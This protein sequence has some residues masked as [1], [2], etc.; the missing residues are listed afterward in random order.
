MDTSSPLRSLLVAGCLFAGCQ[1]GA[2]VDE[3]AVTSDPV[4]AETMTFFLTSIG[5][6]NGAD[7]GGLDG[8]DTHC[9][10]LAEAAGAPTR[11]WRAYLST[12]TVDARDRIGA[13]PWVNS[14]GVTVAASLE[15]LIPDAEGLT[16]ASVL[17]EVGDII[18]GRGDRPNRH[19]VL[20]GTGIDGRVVRTED[21]VLTCSDWTSSDD[22]QAVV[23]HH[24]RVGGGQRPTHWSSA[25]ASRGCSQDNLRSSGGDGLFYC[26]AID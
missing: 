5:P 11:T 4:N 19:D 3:D 8:A 12:A 2:S 6:G 22:G 25:H 26:F 13:G 10:A 7:L 9:A 1:Q 21:G 24:D 23:G 18:N 15:A 20:T 16:K 17:S 14:R